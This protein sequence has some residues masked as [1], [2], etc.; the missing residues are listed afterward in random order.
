MHTQA[1]K[2]MVTRISRACLNSSKKRSNLT[3]SLSSYSCSASAM[4]VIRRFIQSVVTLVGRLNSTRTCKYT[5]IV[6]N[7][8]LI[9]ISVKFPRVASNFSIRTEVN[10]DL[11]HSGHAIVQHELFSTNDQSIRMAIRIIISRYSNE[12]VRFLTNHSFLPRRR[13]QERTQYY[14]FTMSF[15]CDFVFTRTRIRISKVTYNRINLVHE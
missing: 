11:V 10:E 6:I 14:E 4:I 1:A 8:T 12:Y 7:T 13:N 2:E 3:S 5:L 15:S 9:T